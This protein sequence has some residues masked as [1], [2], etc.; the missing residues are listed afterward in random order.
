M[1]LTPENYEKVIRSKGVS[2]D[3]T[4]PGCEEVVVTAVP[5][6]PRKMPVQAV[7]LRARPHVRLKQ[8]PCPSQ[9]YMDMLKQGA[10]ELQLQPD[11]QHIL[12]THPIQQSPVW[13]K[14]LAVYNLIFNFTLSS[15]LKWSGPSRLQSW[16]AFKAYIPSTA[17]ALQRAVGCQ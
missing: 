2:P 15:C 16:C 14:W 6:D 10:A 3:S 4:N 11:Y 8:D 9:R 1:T 13:L 12:S 7:A 5:Y 17:P